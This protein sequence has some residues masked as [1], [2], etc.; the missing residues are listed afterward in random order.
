MTQATQLTPL[1]K[2]IRRRHTGFPLKSAPSTHLVIRQCWAIPSQAIMEK[3]CPNASLHRLLSINLRSSAGV[4]NHES[5]I[6]TSTLLFLTANP[7]A[8]ISRVSG[9]LSTQNSGL[10]CRGVTTV[11]HCERRFFKKSA[12]FFPN[13][14]SSALIGG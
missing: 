8:H 14:C 9:P 6:P 4:F 7:T 13:P 11:W 2:R 1:H 12:I 3:P 10:F 5:C